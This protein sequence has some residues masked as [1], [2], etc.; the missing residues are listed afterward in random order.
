[1]TSALPGAASLQLSEDMVL[2]LKG[3]NGPPGLGAPL[4]S[5]VRSKG[6]GRG[7]KEVNHKKISICFLWL[8]CLTS[9]RGPG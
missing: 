6:R 7:K 3:E 2:M 8:F 1:M 4:F 5:G 9:C